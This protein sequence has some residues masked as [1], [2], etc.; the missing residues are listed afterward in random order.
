MP[1]PYRTDFWDS[2]LWQNVTIPPSGRIGLVVTVPHSTTSWCIIGFSI[3]PEYGLGSVQHPIQFSTKKNIYLLDQLPEFITRGETISLHF[4]LFSTINETFE[5][6]VT[7]FNA[8]N[9]LLFLDGPSGDSTESKIVDVMSNSPTPVSFVVKPMKL[10]ELEIRLNASIMQG[11]ISDSFKKIIK[12]LPEDLHEGKQVSLNFN[13]SF[14][15]PLVG[16]KKGCLQMEL[17]F[18]PKVPAPGF[19]IIN[20]F[21]VSLSY[22]SMQKMFHINPISKNIKMKHILDTEHIH[23]TVIVNDS[24]MI[25]VNWRVRPCYS[26]NIEITK[27][28]TATKLLKQLNVCCSFIPGIVGQHS[29]DTLVE[30]SIPIGYAME[31]HSVQENTTFNPIDSIEVLHDGTTLKVHY[32]NMGIETTCFSVFAYRRYRM[33][34]KHP[35]YIRV[36]DSYRPGNSTSAIFVNFS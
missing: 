36:Q 10:G 15:I 3:H 26:F 34:L 1:E 32:K 24:R 18:L 35:S 21:N 4:T 2:W 5:A 9:Q 28:A 17:S 30:V 29:N 19:G 14:D 16:V 13:H 33:P 7:M 27:Q 31:N 22:G 20:D 11:V 25:T 8:K 6:T 23:V 12:V